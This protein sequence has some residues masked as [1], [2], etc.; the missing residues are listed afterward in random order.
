MGACYNRGYGKGLEPQQ[1][2]P[3]DIGGAEWGTKEG[4]MGMST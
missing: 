2:G 1:R 4:F 3:V